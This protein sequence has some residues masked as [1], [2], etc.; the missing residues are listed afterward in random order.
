MTNKPKF[1]LMGELKKEPCSSS[2]RIPWHERLRIDDVKTYDALIEVVDAFNSCDPEIITRIPSVAA[3]H[4]WLK[5]KNV[6][7]P[8]GTSTFSHFVLS[9]KRG[10]EP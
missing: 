9:R 6:P 4:D 7:V 10:Q 2:V 8:K 5:E 1:S 3:L